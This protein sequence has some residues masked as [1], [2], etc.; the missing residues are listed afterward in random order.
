MA[1]G[2]GRIGRFRQLRQAA[3]LFVAAGTVRRENL[4]VVME[5][6]IV[7]SQAGPVA[8]FLVEEASYLHMA[9]IAFCGQKS[10]VRGHLA[11]AID[12]PVAANGMPGDPGKGE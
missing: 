12:A 2:T 10:V 11:R 3:M 7:A 6:S 1:L 8:G 5:R 9:G 4:V